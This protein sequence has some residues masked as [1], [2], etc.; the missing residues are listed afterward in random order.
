MVK[1][2][3]NINK[4][5]LDNKTMEQLRQSNDFQKEDYL[6]MNKIMDDISRCQEDVEIELKREIPGIYFICN[7]NLNLW[8]EIA[9]S[10]TENGTWFIVSAHKETI[11]EI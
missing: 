1:D 9:E 7:K 3:I 8:V 10:Q 5:V 6:F 2:V 4:I 11:Y